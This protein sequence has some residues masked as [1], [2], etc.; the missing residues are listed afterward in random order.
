MTAAGE[1]E[2]RAI[3]F[4]RISRENARYAT[5]EITVSNGARF[6]ALIVP[7][8]ELRTKTSALYIH[9]RRATSQCYIGITE[10]RVLDR[11]TKGNNYR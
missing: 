5:T 3:S 11:W 6:V 4:T 2:P 9:V 1:A 7:I 8:A 10:Q